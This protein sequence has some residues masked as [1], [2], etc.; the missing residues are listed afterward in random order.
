MVL[1]PSDLFGLC[2]SR[3]EFAFNPPAHWSARAAASGGDETRRLAADDF[4]S[5]YP[6]FYSC[7]NRF[8]M[9]QGEAPERYKVIR[10]VGRGAMGTVYC[11]QDTLLE[12]KVALKVLSPSP[13]EKEP[14]VG[15]ER[16][17]SVGRMMREARA[18]AALDH[19]NIVTVYDVGEIPAST[20]EEAFCFIAMEFIE[21]QSLRE[22]VG[23]KDIAIERRIEWLADVARALAFAHTRGIIH[24]D[25]K[26]ENVMVREDGVLKVLDFGLAR[27]VVG[28][29]GAGIQVLPTLTEE[30]Q[31]VGTPLYMAPEQ[32]RGAVLDGRAD[33]FSWGIVAFELLAGRLPWPV[34]HD[35]IQ[36][37]AQMLMNEPVSISSLAPDVAP[38]LAAIVH[39]TLARY[40]EERFETMDRLVD[41]LQAIHPWRG[42]T[43]TARPVPP[44]SNENAPGLQRD[45]R[46]PR[47]VPGPATPALDAAPVVRW[48]RIGRRV[49]APVAAVAAVAAAIA[50]PRLGPTA[51]TARANG[52]CASDADCDSGLSCDAGRCESPPRCRSNGECTKTMGAP[53]ICRADRG[54]CVALG[55]DDCHVVAEANDLENGATVWFGT[56]FPLVG[57][58]A[59]SFG[60]RE[61]QA[62][63]LARSD[64]AQMLRGYGARS[65]VKGV[66]PLGVVACDDAVDASRAARHL[67]DDLGVP[68]IIGFR[69]S[70]EL[71]DL[72]TSLFIPRAVLAIA[73]LNTSPI[74]ANLPRTPGEPRMVFRTTYSSAQAAAPIGLLVSDVLE[75]EIRAQQ[76]A[77]RGDAPRRVALVLQDDAAGIGFADSLFRSLRFNGRSA[78]ENEGSYREI[79]YAFDTTEKKEPDFDQIADKLLRFAPH[80]VV[81][82]GADEA[83][84][85]ILGPLERRWKVD[86]FRPHYLKP[87]ALAPEVLAFVRRRAERKRRFLSLTSLS[88]TQ[89]NAR[90]VSRYSAQ[91]AEKITRTFAPNSSYD[92]FYVLAYATLALGHEPVTGTSLARAIGRLLPPGEPID[93][94]PGGIF[95]ALS[96]LS[97]DKHID[98]N[99][100][101]GRLDFDTDTGEAPVDLAVLCVRDDPS[102]ASAESVESGLI[103]DA[104]AHALRGAMHCP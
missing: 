20:S 24:R 32:M 12:R 35:S 55:S 88:T 58:E 86:T 69:T 76:G 67:V 30:G 18:A 21:G 6:L 7:A 14:L 11:A 3:E 72:A 10:L 90:F 73:A 2:R 37:V 8:G 13:I 28:T 99:G 78:L 50:S 15:S 71:I 40:K 39:R 29:T 38:E 45:A 80:V 1:W 47:T 97:A 93:V 60:T 46:T 27:R 53:S 51:H 101:T 74:I 25:I 66:H 49:A 98:L 52:T 41:A 26:P 62:V 85:R 94:G 91:Y 89:A 22:Y 44:I 23:R 79:A 68:A 59:Q 65:D 34:G 83:F 33:Q 61:F 56:M 19:P 4:A 54:G 48:R 5:G 100:A 16:Q 77:L 9:S 103:Y 36:V 43:R 84:L 87:T 104:R 31:A 82:F 63:E 17:A 75:P 95:E 81:H 70:K 64:F 92:A 96:A 57:D 42:S 102:A